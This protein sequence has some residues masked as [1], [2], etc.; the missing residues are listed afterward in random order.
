MRRVTTPSLSRLQDKDLDA[1]HTN[2]PPSPTILKHDPAQHDL[3]TRQ[4]SPTGTAKGVVGKFCS[5]TTGN[6]DVS[7]PPS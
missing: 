3:S 6:S 7:T 5:V 2:T 4:F 1:Q